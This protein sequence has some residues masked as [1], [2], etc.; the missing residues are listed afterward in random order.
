MEEDIFRFKQFNVNQKGCTMKINTDGVLLAVKANQDNQV[1]YVLDIG[2]GTG[3]M[4]LMLAQRYPHAY[5][6]AIDIDEDAVLCARQNFMNS[7]FKDRLE[8]HHTG[9]EDYQTTRFY[10]LIVSNPPFFINS[11]KN[12]DKRKSLSRHS[13]IEFYK[14]MFEKCGRFLTLTGAFQIIWPLEIRD[15]V[16]S[17]SLDADLYLNEETYIQSFPHSDPFRVIS[18]FRKLPPDL[19]VSKNFEIYEK[20]G[21]YSAYYQSLLKPF[22]INY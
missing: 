7:P 2:T 18:V 16:L 6:E 13:S 1:E 14:K 3:V 17:L 10:D 9:I 15:Q 4:A 20:E 5:I 11:L 22:F 21:V 19:Y 12:A 8:V